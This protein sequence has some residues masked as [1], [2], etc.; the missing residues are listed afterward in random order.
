MEPAMQDCYRVGRANSY[1]LNIINPYLMYKDYVLDGNEVMKYYM[2]F[3]TV[4]Q[5]Q[6]ITI[7][8]GLHYY[9]DKIRNLENIPNTVSV[10]KNNRTL[11]TPPNN[12]FVFIQLQVCTPDKMVDI[13]F[14]NAYNNTPLK[15]KDNIYSDQKIYF[16]SF[17]N[18][19]LDTGLNLTTDN[20]AK[21]FVRHTGLE[22][23]YSPYYEELAISFDREN[24]SI[25]FKQPIA[26]EEFNYTVFI[27]NYGA[28]KNKGLTLCSVAENIK[29][30][31][32]TKTINSSEEN[33]KIDIDFDSPELVEY[34]EFDAIVLA[35]QVNNGKL[36]FLSNL[37]QTKVPNRGSGNNNTTLII[38]IVVLGVVLVAG[39]ILIFFCLKKYKERPNSKKLDAKQTSLAM[40]DNENEKMII[41]TATEKNE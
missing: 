14:F 37:I 36:M 38:V 35:E 22:E 10:S 6:N 16:T 5:S 41:S 32:Y 12:I 39:G 29:L 20:S 9:Q 28:L 7:T 30:A 31:H 3:K 21:V 2:G 27:D 17:E 1:K 15:Y 24:R 11:L 8:P 26:E 4:D 18:I 33:V 40:V 13:E 34:K 19:R 25:K 23:E